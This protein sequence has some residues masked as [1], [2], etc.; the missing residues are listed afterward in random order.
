MVAIVVV[1]VI[2][3]IMT[4]AIIIAFTVVMFVVVVIIVGHR[5][6]GKTCGEHTGGGDSGIDGLHGTPVSVV[7]GHAAH[8]GADG[9]NQH[10]DGAPTEHPENNGLSLHI[11]N[12]E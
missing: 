3:I 8:A 10:D 6:A 11:R 4:V 5:V 7:G 9:R 2:A 1:M 12:N